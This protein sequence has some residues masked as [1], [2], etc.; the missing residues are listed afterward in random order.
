MGIIGGIAGGALGKKLGGDGIGGDIL[1][2]LF[3]AGGG[4]IPWFETGGHVDR[5]GVAYLHKIEFV[6]PANAKATKKQKAIVRK[7]KRK[8]RGMPPR[9]P[10]RKVVFM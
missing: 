9:D 7:N 2:G 6:V 8:A 5:N 1:G 3:S 4:L 10:R